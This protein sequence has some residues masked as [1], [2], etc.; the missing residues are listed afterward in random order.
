MT[1]CPHCHTSS[2]VVM[3][4]ALANPR[5]KKH[6]PEPLAGSSESSCLYHPEYKASSICNTCGAFVCQLC[7]IHLQDDPICPACLER[8]TLG[9]KNR[10]LKKN[11]YLWD[12]ISLALAFFVPASLALWFMSLFSAPYALFLAVRHWKDPGLL[13]KPSKLRMSLA[14]LLALAQ[15]G[16]WI[17]LFLYGFNALSKLGSSN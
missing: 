2:R 8:Q 1:P 16:G 11:H 6:Q 9:G 5:R 7:E 14:A 10:I 3:F 15:I 12:N 13:R 17:L 4:P